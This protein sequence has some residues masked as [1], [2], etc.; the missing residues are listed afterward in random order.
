MAI[1]VLAVA[2][3]F[4]P[5]VALAQRTERPSITVG[6]N[7]LVSSAPGR[8]KLMHVEVIADVDPRDPKHIIACSMVSTRP[9][10]ESRSVLFS[11]FDG[12]VTWSDGVQS[13]K[14]AFD[15]DCWVGR[16]GTAYLLSEMN[17][18]GQVYVWRA[19]DGRHWEKPARITNVG[20]RPWL[21]VD[22][23]LSSPYAGRVYACYVTFPKAIDR[24]G[25]RFTVLNLVTS[26][27][28]GA[29]FGPPINVSQTN[30]DT[31][32]L[33]LARPAVMSNGNL[34][35]VYSRRVPMILDRSRPKRDGSID[36]LISTDGGKTLAEPVHVADE[37]AAH[38][39]D[40]PTIE[41]VAIDPGSPSF[42]DRI[43]V[44]WA[45][46]RSGRAEI[47]LSFSPDSGKTWSKPHRVNDDRPA[48]SLE[49]GPDDFLP[50]V[51]V[52]ENGIVG[53][54]WYDRRDNPD[55]VGYNVRFSASLDG[56]ETW[57]ASVKVSERPNVFEQTEF[58]D[59]WPDVAAA[60]KSRAGE[61]S[62]SLSNSTWTIGGHTAGLAAGAGGAFHL[63]WV[64]NRSRTQQ[65][66]TATAVVNGEVV[67]NGSPVLSAMHDLTQQVTVGLS[68]P[69]LD[70]AT[71]TLSASVEIKN[72]SS[73]T[74]H[75]PFVL[76][77]TAF[78]SANAA[79]VATNA[80]NGQRGP[81]ATYDFPETT[82]LPKSATKP[83]RL[84][85][86][87]SDVRS[88]ARNEEMRRTLFDAESRVFGR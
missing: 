6:R 40:T 80:D 44:A 36:A 9:V 35:I 1:T 86:R 26:A 41:S 65:I 81:G 63:L 78:R 75:G 73:D 18:S 43:Y 21:I 54:Q 51:A 52:N 77:L 57:L 48:R 67:L 13:G 12:G 30:P 4:L 31:L 39:T 76:R 46:V 87:L 47:L 2:A 59:I 37:Y 8:E 45:D 62:I 33:M 49:Q 15:P 23:S 56:G 53:V 7:V 10:S 61:I 19:P 58:P 29:S 60:P 32:D 24:G 5:I 71:S 50:V 64:D 70:R 3:S 25:K 88:T 17:D 85:F 27:D 72:T 69:S 55:N 84:T 22:R 14:S 34:I 28:G 79:L 83:K 68:D 16:D 74:L 20:D 82:L 42:K 11:S 66:Y 38:T